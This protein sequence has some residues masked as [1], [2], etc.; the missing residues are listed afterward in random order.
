[1]I[2]IF[3]G[4]GLDNN[5]LSDS[6]G[7]RRHR[8]GRWDWV[9]APEKSAPSARYQHSSLFVGPLMVIVGGR[10]N[11]VNERLSLEVFNTETS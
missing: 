4:R 10:T 1:M 8:T 7:L 11:S 5:P 2:V 6:W 9:R 3:G